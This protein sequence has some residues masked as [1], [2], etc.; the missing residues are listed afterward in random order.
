MNN[1]FG[2]IHPGLPQNCLASLHF[3]ALLMHL[4]VKVYIS[5]RESVLRFQ[6]ALATIYNDWYFLK[7]I[8]KCTYKA[9]A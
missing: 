8:T 6:D 1:A 2:L 4:H 3:Y 5:N 9:V 7:N